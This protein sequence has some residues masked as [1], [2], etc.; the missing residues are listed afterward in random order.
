MSD[1]YG[2][3]RQVAMVTDLNKCIGCQSC[4]IACKTQW[5]RNEGMEGMWWNTV[6]SQPGEGTPR[7]YEAMGGGFRDGKPVPGVLP[8]QKQFGTAW[9]FNYEEVFYGGDGDSYLQPSEEPT[10]GMNFDEDMGAGDYPNNYYFYLPRICN[11][12]TRPACLEACPR[13]AIDKRKSDGIVVIN[14]DRC[15]GYQ[16]CAEACPYKKI[17][18]N[19]VRHISQKC[20]FCFPRIEKGVATA[21]TRQCPGRVRFLGFLDDEDGPIYKLVKEWRVALPLHAEYGTFPNVFYVPPLSPEKLD[22]NG[23]PTG[24]P[25]IPG[26][27]LENL[28][29]PDVHEAL[30]TIEQERERAGQGKKSE[31]MDI[32]IARRWLDM[33]PDFD[34]HPTDVE[35]VESTITFREFKRGGQLA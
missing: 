5:T 10:W 11:H 14:E 9:E 19:A 21:C 22:E 32:L 15:R 13:K 31:L 1:E 17:Y 35:P 12:C 3:D 8:T 33:F 30:I 20:F 7:G 16:F 23:D 28:F 34:T 27:Y 25:R 26:E 24:E 2:S 6:N 29:G 4:S 18:Y